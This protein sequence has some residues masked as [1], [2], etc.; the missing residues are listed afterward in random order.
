VAKGSLVIDG[1]TIPL[2]HSYAHR[3]DNGEGLL[4]GPELRVL[5][6]DRKVDHALLAGIH[7]V[8]LAELA[9]SGAVQGVLLTVDPRKAAAGMRGVLLVAEKNP[10]KSLTSFSYSGGDGG[11]RKLTVGNN[12]VLGEAHH[13]SLRGGP[14]FEYTATFSAPLFHEEPITGKLSGAQA[15][16]SA[17]FRRLA[18]YYKALRAGDFEAAR[19]VATTET[20]RE[21]DALIAQAGKPA[22]LKMIREM[23]PVP[24]LK[25]KPQVFVR[26]RR[27]LIV[28]QAGESV[29]KRGAGA[30]CCSSGCDRGG[31]REHAGSFGT[32]ARFGVASIGEADGTCSALRGLGMQSLTQRG[33]KWLVD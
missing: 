21:I 27:A 3:H 7:T 25:D 33:G 30:P 19:Q 9:R 18:S 12:R 8:R 20:F 24:G 2:A 31:T 13:Q 28:F 32:E 11:F 14:A 16:E 10:T 29:P 23:S 22:A 6:T 5:L 4:D 17:P 26:G 15:M 1:R